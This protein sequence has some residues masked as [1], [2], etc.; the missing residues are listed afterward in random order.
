MDKSFNN[1]IVGSE[2]DA[3]LSSQEKRVAKPIT[4]RF[5]SQVYVYIV[6]ATLAL[7]MAWLLPSIYEGANSRQTT[8]Q[9]VDGHI[10]YATL[11][12]G[13]NQSRFIDN[14]S[15]PTK[16]ASQQNADFVALK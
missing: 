1:Q 9:H 12:S 6:A 8:A 15:L 16:T 3:A 10:A 2:F 7:A 14:R 5:T 4:L 11:V 13:S